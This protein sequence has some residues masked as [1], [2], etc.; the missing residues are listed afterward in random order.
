M[1]ALDEYLDG[2]A[3]NDDVF[4][5]KGCGDVSALLMIY[6]GLIG[7]TTAILDLGRGKGL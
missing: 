3:D 1:S 6:I 7:L 5:C 4:P 2:S